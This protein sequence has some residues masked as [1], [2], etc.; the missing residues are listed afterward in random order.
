VPQPL[1]PNDCAGACQ[2]LPSS[3]A[4][5]RHGSCAASGSTRLPAAR[6]EG[7]GALARAGDVRRSRQS[8]AR[9]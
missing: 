2:A 8:P 5:L 4:V 1:L 9:V 3:S 7:L 6:P